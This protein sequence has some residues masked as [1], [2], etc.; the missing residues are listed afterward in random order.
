M[1]CGYSP[2]RSED[3]KELIRE[4][5]EANIEFHEKYWRNVSDEGMRSRMQ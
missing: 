2:F 1:L 4:T 3:M 5:T